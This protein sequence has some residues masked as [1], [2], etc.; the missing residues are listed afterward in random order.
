[1]HA[2]HR[3]SDPSRKL[4]TAPG[5]GPITTC[6]RAASIGD[7]KNVDGSRQVAA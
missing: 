6:A 5:I 3:N 2:W 4:A 1:M 7:A